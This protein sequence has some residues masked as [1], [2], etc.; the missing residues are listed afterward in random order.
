MGA[1][2]VTRAH[3][4]CDKPTLT[5]WVDE[6]SQTDAHEHGHSYSGH[7][8][9][10]NGLVIEDAKTFASIAE[11]EDYLSESLVKWENLIAVPALCPIK[12]SA[13]TLK[14]DAVYKKLEDLQKSLK[15]DIWQ[16]PRLIV[17]RTKAGSSKFKACGSCGSKISVLHLAGTH[18][19]VCRSDFLTT[20]TDVKK[21]AAL[22][23]KEAATAE[24]LKIRREYL[25]KKSAG[26]GAPEKL[27]LVGGM[28]AS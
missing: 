5:N 12:V 3:R 11:A 4:W 13:E 9:M 8:N 24:K 28:C 20:P 23:E 14:A 16:Y 18:C 7:W 10:C 25:S 21:F 2:L 17:S 22:Q 15:D 26:S 6:V 27:W 1:S 19:P